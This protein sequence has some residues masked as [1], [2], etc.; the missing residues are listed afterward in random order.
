MN[1]IVNPILRGF[2][3]D[4]SII[5]VG[6]DYYIATSTF[7]WYP[8]VQIHHSRDL[9]HWRLL[10]HPLTRSSQLD[11]LGNPSSGGV[12]APCLSYSN[13]IYYLVYTD[14]KSHIG[15]FKDTHNYLVYA[16]AIEGPWSEP[17]YLNSSGFD[18]SLFHDED[19]RKWL[20]NM[21]W[22]HRKGRNHFGGIVIQE[23]D[24]EQRKLVGPVHT[25]FHGTSLGLT[26]GPHL[27]RH[28]SYY[29]LLTAEGGTRYEHAVTMAR[30]EP[31][32]GPYQVDPANPVLTS[33]FN[34]ELPLQRAGHA[35]L[36]ET[37]AGEW[38]MVHLCGRP[39][40]SSRMCNL[41]RETAIQKVVWT[42]DGW[43]RLAGGGCEPQVEVEAPA[44]LPEHSFPGQ[45]LHGTGVDHFDSKTLAIHFN[46]LREPADESWLTLR[47]RPGYLRLR[48]RESFS[49][50]Y[51]Q[52][53]VARRQ[54][55]FIAEAETVIEFEPDNYQQMAGLVYYYNARNWYYLRISRDEKLGKSLAI[56]T[57]DQGEYDEPLDQEISV[58]GCERVYLKLTLDHERAQF[59]YS[60]DGVDW[61]AVGPV[62]DAGR[63]SDENAESRHGGV[64]LDQG[65]TGAFIGVCVQDLS[66]CR[67]H[68]D[69]DYFTYREYGERGEHLWRL[70]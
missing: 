19:G 29:Y 44:A 4:P 13:G 17:V 48:G 56:L 26:E 61:R 15:P 52:S 60:T 57:S 38:Y 30:S 32:L 27:Y 66:G 25:I 34:P 50:A 67:Q 23:Y 63:M 20:L 21:V 5:R 2:N 24:E 39:L 68:G 41:G 55:S 37:A 3:P 58:D 9:K 28:G 54:Q 10:T 22:D 59:Y 35:D 16:S 43:L 65:F 69:F 14:V 18:P 49:S 46:T 51:G 45:S 47:E 62:L 7:E 1:T 11:M 42:E 70:A 33:R 64:L 31:I 40:A 53:L 36:V 12:W 8:G 6:E